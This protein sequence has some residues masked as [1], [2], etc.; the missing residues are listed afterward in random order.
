MIKELDLKMNFAVI[1]NN[2]VQKSK[3][4][5]YG[6]ANSPRVTMEQLVE[7]QNSGFVEV[8]SHTYAGHDPGDDYQCDLG[9]FLMKPAYNK[10][11]YRQ[12]TQ[13]EF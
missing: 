5:G 4:P 10:L 9:Q 3:D 12:E 6:E 2:S 7:M 13:T 1:L 11:L 8:G